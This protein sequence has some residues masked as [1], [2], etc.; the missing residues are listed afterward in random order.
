MASRSMTR[1]AVLGAGALM[2]AAAP[3]V[4]AAGPAPAVYVTDGAR[5]EG[6]KGTREMVH[7][8]CLSRP[9]ADGAVSVRY[10]TEQRGAKSGSDFRQETGTLAWGSGDSRCTT[11]TTTLRADARRERDERFAIRLSEPEGVRVPD[12]VAVQTVLNDDVAADEIVIATAVYSDGTLQTSFTP[13]LTCPSAHPYMVN[14]Q[15]SHAQFSAVAG[16]DMNKPDSVAAYLRDASELQGPTDQFDNTT[17]YLT[18]LNAGRS[19][20][21]FS[22]NVT[23]YG[24]GSNAWQIFVH[25]TNDTTQANSFVQGPGSL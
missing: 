20:D 11:F 5:Y 16:V 10:T 2:L 12:P 13:A 14:R 24:W 7:S 8:A 3:S 25:C 1:R 9:P 22:N 4:L 19:G 18:G 6:T 17:I 23:N 21:L 15:Y